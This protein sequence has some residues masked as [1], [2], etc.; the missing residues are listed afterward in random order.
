[1]EAFPGAAVLFSNFMKLYFLC[2]K[3][4]PV[5]SL[6]RQ[7]EQPLGFV[8]AMGEALGTITFRPSKALLS[9]AITGGQIGL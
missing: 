4:N 3:R 2:K 9:W 5:S 1:M 8:S 7:K 6:D